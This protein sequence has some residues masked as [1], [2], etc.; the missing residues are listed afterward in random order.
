MKERVVTASKDLRS[1]TFGLT[2]LVVLA[3]LPVGEVRAEDTT[4]LA[5]SDCRYEQGE[6]KSGSAAFPTDDVFRPLMADPK[7]PQFFAS[8]Q[9]AQVRTD[10]TSANVGS[11]GFGENFGF[12]TKR[13]G[14]SGWQVGLLAGVFSQFNLDA[15]SSDLINTDFV[16]G[17][18]FH[19]GQGTGRRGCGSII[20]A[21][22]SGTNFCWG[23]RGSI[24]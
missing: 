24:G 3:A 7:Q 23:G 15:P 2:A 6:G 18:P 14:C 12:Y 13:E 1:V 20:K 11:V 5:V 9:A 17:V 22:I 16:V 8:W 19:G 10:R 21:A 4:A